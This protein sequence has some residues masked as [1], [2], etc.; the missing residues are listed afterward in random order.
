MAVSVADKILIIED[1]VDVLETVA[2]V[3]G[4]EG[5]STVGALN[6]NQGI[7]A[8]QAQHPTLVITDLFMP[9]KEGI[10]T[11]LELRQLRPDLK[12]I[13][14]SGGGSLRNMEVL[15]MAGKLGASAILAKPFEPEE[16]LD[17]VRSVLY[18]Q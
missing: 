15:E 6:G 2:R 10:E 11:I 7:A 12:I 17:T 8:V 18:A 16:L 3:L 14:I 4:G 13:A 5:Y 9:D 1:D